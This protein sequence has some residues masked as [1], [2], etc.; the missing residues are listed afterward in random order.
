[1]ARIHRRIFMRHAFADFRVKAEIHRRKIFMHIRAQ[2]RVHEIELRW[3]SM[4]WVRRVNANRF[5]KVHIQAARI[6]QRAWTRYW[7]RRCVSFELEMR[8]ILR[9]RAAETI[10]K[11]HRGRKCR[12]MLRRRH[13]EEASITIQRTWRG[14]VTR[15][16]VKYKRRC[17]NMFWTD[18]VSS[19]MNSGHTYDSKLMLRTFPCKSPGRVLAMKDVPVSQTPRF[20]KRRRGISKTVIRAVKKGESRRRLKLPPI[21]RF[22]HT[23]ALENKRKRIRSKKRRAFQPLPSPSTF[24]KELAKSFIKLRR[25]VVQKRAKWGGNLRNRKLYR[26]QARALGNLLTSLKNGKQVINL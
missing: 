19:Q 20:L 25:R 7:K 12:D 10:Q 3:K 1:M 15:E 26:N 14:H 4:S 16:R 5:K 23:I 6:I 8:Q 17:F 2:Q 13:R 24:D 21:E 9:N 18:L 11:T 22:D